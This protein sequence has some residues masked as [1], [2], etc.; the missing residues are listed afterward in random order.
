MQQLIETYRGTVYPWH[1]DHMGH[2]NVMWYV[3]KFDEG[4]WNLFFEAGITPKYLRENNRGMAGLQQNITYKRELYAGDVVNV[5]SGVLE[6]RDKVVRFRHEM[7][8]L[9]NRETAATM[10]LTVAHID[11]AKRKS[12]PFPAAIRGCL[13]GLMIA[14]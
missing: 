8:N 6:V 9:E 12:C 1:C 2:M 3:S 4:T 11:T 7:T 10:E 14:A 13:Q 5:R